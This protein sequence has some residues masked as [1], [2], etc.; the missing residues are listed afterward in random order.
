MK[1]SR[2]RLFA[3][4][5]AVLCLMLAPMPAQAE[6][7]PAA[8]TVWA[9][10]GLW[11]DEGTLSAGV[12]VENY[13]APLTLDSRAFSQAEGLLRI[14][15]QQQEQLL[16]QWIF[17]P[18]AEG[19]A[20][21]WC[22]YGDIDAR[23]PELE[24]SYRLGSY[25]GL[26]FE[27]A[28]PLP[29]G[30]AQLRVRCLLP[31][32]GETIFVYQVQP[33]NKLTLTAEAPGEEEG[34]VTFDL[35]QGG[36]YLLTSQPIWEEDTAGLIRSVPSGQTLGWDAN[37]LFTLGEFRQR[38]QA[39]S[40]PRIVLNTS[41]QYLVSGEV[42]REAARTYPDKTLVLRG[43][44]YQWEFDLD[45]LPGRKGLDWFD[46]RVYTGSSVTAGW[47]GTL[48]RG[49]EVLSFAHQDALP[50]TARLTWYRSTAARLPVDYAVWEMGE[51]GPVLRQDACCPDGGRITWTVDRLTDTILTSAPLS[52]RAE[53]QQGSFPR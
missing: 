46:T 28:G 22:P 11:L 21:D 45:D 29:L 15:V 49:Q 37:V 32:P 16:M 47:E 36:D 1:N 31:D 30:G 7:L 10:E 5:L 9:G 13:A 20:E 25:Q 27:H 41:T 14:G 33:D 48:G 3:G 18:Q 52:V 43:D 23:F 24:E 19:E 34:F 38:A 51:S 12:T 42:F 53:M 2:K 40:G 44:G 8:E 35:E 39:S 6:E 17:Q 50:G 4:G 26:S